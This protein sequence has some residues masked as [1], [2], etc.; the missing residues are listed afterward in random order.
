MVTVFFL[1]FLI[2]LDYFEITKSALTAML[3]AL[4]IG[5]IIVGLAAQNTLI[6]ISSPE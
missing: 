6:A 2:L 3:A 1:A 4:G 5:G